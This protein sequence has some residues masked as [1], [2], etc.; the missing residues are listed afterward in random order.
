METI[1]PYLHEVDNEDKHILVPIRTFKDMIY[2]EYCMYATQNKR[3]PDR[4]DQIELD[5]GDETKR[6]SKYASTR[7]KSKVDTYWTFCSTYGKRLQRF[8]EFLVYTPMKMG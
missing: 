6:F 3:M 5:W 2:Y 8:P 1:Q 7:Y 4:L